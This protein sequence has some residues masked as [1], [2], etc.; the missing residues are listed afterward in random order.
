MWLCQNNESVSKHKYFTLR[1]SKLNESKGNKT[2]LL[3]E[4]VCLGEQLESSAPQ[5][6][7]WGNLVTSVFQMHAWLSSLRS[8]AV[9][10]LNPEGSFSFPIFSNFLFIYY[11]SF[12][13]C[14]L[15][16]FISRPYTSVFAPHRSAPIKQNLRENKKRE[17]EKLKIS[18][19]KHQCDTVSPAVN[20]F[21]PVSLLASVYCQQPWVWFKG[22]GFYYT[23]GAGPP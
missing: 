23:V 4:P 6:A 9:T 16:P 8:R 19:W 21:V 14:I 13:L 2:R 17:G 5:S 15:L 12:T 20:P 1:L 10:M 3:P 7:F 18:S 11:V 22:S